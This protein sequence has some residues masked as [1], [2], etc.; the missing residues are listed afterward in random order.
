MQ[1]ELNHSL[2]EERKVTPEEVQSAFNQALTELESGYDGK[3]R[4]KPVRVLRLLNV[5]QGRETE[6]ISIEELAEAFIDTVDSTKSASTAISSLNRLFDTL[7]IDLQIER[8][9]YYQFRRK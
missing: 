1:E 6:T 2:N 3:P 7:G 8:T 4:R 9:S 5:F